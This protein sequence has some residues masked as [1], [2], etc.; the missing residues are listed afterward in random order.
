MQANKVNVF[1]DGMIITDDAINLVPGDVIQ[2]TGG[3]KVPADIRVISSNGLK[4]NNSSLTG[5][6]LDI[7]LGPEA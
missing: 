3:E 2:V 5:E 7:K 4:V 1:R 6:N